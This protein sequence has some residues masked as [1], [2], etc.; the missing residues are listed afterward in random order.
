MTD[1]LATLSLMKITLAL[2]AAMDAGVWTETEEGICGHCYTVGQVYSTS[3]DATQSF[4][5]TS[6]SDVCKDC[7]I[8]RALWNNYLAL[9][10]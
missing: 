4:I 10:P 3:P 9:H 2:E 8:H 6:T 7:L 1:D 5:P